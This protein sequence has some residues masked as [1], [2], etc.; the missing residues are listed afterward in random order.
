MESLNLTL[1]IDWALR[2]MQIITF[3]GVILKISF[4]KN[5]Y[6]DNVIMKRMKFEELDS[7]NMDF[8]FIQSFEDIQD[9]TY[10]EYFVLYPK[11]VDIISLKFIEIKYGK[12]AKEIEEIRDTKKNVRNHTCIVISTI[13]PEGAPH[14]RVRWETSNGEIGEYTF[15]YNGFNGNS[16]MI[17]YRYKYTLKRKLMYIFGLN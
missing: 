17:S 5:G 1:L 4:N 15:Y 10:N 7:L 11:N 16:D 2:I 8:S 3:I 6:S 14:L 12:N 9:S 13:L